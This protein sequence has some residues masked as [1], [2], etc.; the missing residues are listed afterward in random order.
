MIKPGVDAPVDPAV[1][2]LDYRQLYYRWEREQW[3]AGAIDLTEDRRQWDELFPPKH[4]GAF[5][6]AL[7]SF[8]IP[9]EI[10]NMLVRFVD[11]APTE[12]QQVFLT[13]QLADSARHAVFHDRFASEVL[14]EGAAG[15]GVRAGW[16]NDGW[17]I[18]STEMLPAAS[19]AIATDL[20]NLDRLVE[21]IALYHLVIEGAVAFTGRRFLLDHAR[22]NDLLPGW[23]RGS[24]D[25][26][27]DDARHVDF[28]TK[29]LRAM[30]EKDRHYADVVAGMLAKAVPIIR[31]TF[32]VPDGDPSYLDPLSYGPGDLTTF[33]LDALKK[34]AD[35]I[36]LE[37][38]P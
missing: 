20:G 10:T 12:E 17:R 28:A 31:A 15:V 16:L 35:L 27:R 36:G 22:T 11:A 14:A 33:A 3:S 37:P 8:A 30:I 9:D 4:Q 5:R 21:G 1:L 26:A 29:F 23:C 7:A 18:L 19:N 32:E 34:R 2:D 13:T 6:W 38:I 24:T 25:I